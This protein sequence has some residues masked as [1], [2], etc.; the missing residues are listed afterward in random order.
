MMK[1]KHYGKGKPKTLVLLHGEDVSSWMW[2]EALNL[3]SREYHCITLD[4]PGHGENRDMEFTIDRTVR[5]LSQIIYKA[6]PERKIHLAG[7]GLGG[8]IALKFAFEHPHIVESVILSGVLL[9]PKA[10]RFYHKWSIDSNSSLKNRDFSI[11]KRMKKL[12]VPLMKTTEF[13]KEAL[14]MKP[15]THQAV[16]QEMMEFKMPD[17]APVLYIPALVMVGEDEDFEVRRSLPEVKK[18]FYRSQNVRIK[19]GRNLWMMEKPQVFSRLVTKFIEKQHVMDELVAEAKSE[20]IM[21]S[22]VL[23]VNPI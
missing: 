8:Q 14:Y 21:E 2:K 4:L 6:L 12:G 9:D 10:Y 19:Q 18:F 20:E 15:E 11:K 5:V 17:Y 13:T 7:V 16:R 1:L 23:P 3:L 22:E